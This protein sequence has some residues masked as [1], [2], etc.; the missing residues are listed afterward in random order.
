LVTRLLGLG[1]V[2]AETSPPLAQLKIFNF[3]SLHLNRVRNWVGMF[4]SPAH[5][6]CNDTVG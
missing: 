6:P 4:E 2:G 5:Q 3:R 1:R